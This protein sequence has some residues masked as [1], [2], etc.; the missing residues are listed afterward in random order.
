MKEA[1]AAQPRVIR[2]RRAN[3]RDAIA[4]VSIAAGVD[5]LESAPDGHIAAFSGGF[6]CPAHTG[7]LL[8]GLVAAMYSIRRTM[9]LSFRL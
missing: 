3:N 5:L 8:T 2:H 1:Y 4:I 9:R 6:L 7:V